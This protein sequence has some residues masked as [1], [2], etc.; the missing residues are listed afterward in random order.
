MLKPRTGI[1]AFVYLIYLRLNPLDMFRI[2][3]PS[4]MF[5]MTA[6]I[7]SGV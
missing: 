2:K 4:F 1:R 5:E 7:I 6:R 3:L